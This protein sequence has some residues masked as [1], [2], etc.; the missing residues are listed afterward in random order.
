MVTQ[1]DAFAGRRRP[2]RKSSAARCA[3]ARA[4]RSP[5]CSPARARSTP[6]WA[7]AS[8]RPSPP[9]APPSTAAPRSSTAKLER[10]LLEL[11]HDAGEPARPDGLHP[12][13]AVRARVRAV[14]SCGAPGASSRRRCSATASASTSPPASPASSRL[15]DGLGLVAERGRLMQALPAGGAMA[16][17]FAAP[18]IVEE[19]IASS[20]RLAI[21]AINGPEN[22]VVSGDAAALG[23]VVAALRERG[24]ESRPLAVSHAFHSPLMD[25][26]LDALEAAASRVALRAPTLR[27]VSNVTGEVAGGE[28]ADPAYWRRHVREPVRFRARHAGPARSGLRRLPRDRTRARAD[29][30]GRQVPLRRACLAALAA[31]RSRRVRR[32]AREPRPAA[33]GRRSRRL[34]GVQSRQE[35]LA[36]DL[37]VRRRPPLDRHDPHRRRHAGRPAARATAAHRR[38][39]EDLRDAARRRPARLARRSPRRRRR[40]RPRHRLCRDGRRGGAQ[41]ARQGRGDPRP[42]PAR[43]PDPERRDHRATGCHAAR[44]RHRLRNPGP[45]RG[46]QFLAPACERHRDPHRSGHRLG[47]AR[48]A[49]A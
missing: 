36:A 43:A 45:R 38:Q 42:G 11:L 1:L 30:H 20:N 16:A 19:A 4:R 8:T 23:E 26:A 33:H 35:S 37:P 29:R 40:D 7:A 14:P 48:I 28:V 5:S 34:G 49:A 12:A 17:V 15:E 9:S 24:I 31:A 2:S 32:D 44:R 39:R 27:L 3:L 6:A 13:G 22:V 46:H 18:D 47:A 41:A 10:P 25:P 21:A